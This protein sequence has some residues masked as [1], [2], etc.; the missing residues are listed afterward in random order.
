MIFLNNKFYWFNDKRFEYWCKPNNDSLCAYILYHNN[1]LYYYDELSCK[2]YYLHKK[3]FQLCNNLPLE[4]QYFAKIK[5]CYFVLLDDKSYIEYHSHNKLM[6]VFPNGTEELISDKPGIDKFI[7]YKDFIYVF[8][9]ELIS[10]K[11]NW[12]LHHITE[13]NISIIPGELDLYCINDRIFGFRDGGC[14]VVFNL[15]S[16]DLELNFKKKSLPFV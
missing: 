13:L 1:I 4:I 15:I 9:N 6:R 16:D 8:M 14:G 7:C 11:Y 10:F 12:K 2:V 5:P 3:E